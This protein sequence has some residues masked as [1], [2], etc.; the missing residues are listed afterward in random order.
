MA[1]HPDSALERR[2]TYCDRALLSIVKWEREWP[3][4]TAAR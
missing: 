4:K 1:I 2:Q 3:A